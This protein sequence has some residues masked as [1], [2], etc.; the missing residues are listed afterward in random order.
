[1]SS[2][3]TLQVPFNSG[4][5]SRTI[6]F[7]LSQCRKSFWFCILKQSPQKLRITAKETEKQSIFS[8]QFSGLEFQTV[9]NSEEKNHV[10]AH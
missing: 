2:E 4:L 5:H 6:Q 3:L 10:E 1:M 9:W 7:E 8:K